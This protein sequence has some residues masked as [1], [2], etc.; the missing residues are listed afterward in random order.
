MPV[1][2]LHRLAVLSLLVLFSTCAPPRAT[3]L[4]V[5]E[6]GHL[7][8]QPERVPVD[9]GRLL[10]AN[11]I[12]G[13]GDARRVYEGTLEADGVIRIAGVPEGPWVLELRTRPGEE[14]PEDPPYV[15][16]H[17]IVGGEG[18][19]TVGSRYWARRPKETFGENSRLT[20]NLGVPEG[21]WDG[22][23]LTFVSVSSLFQREL[24]FDSSATNQ[25][26]LPESGATTTSGWEVPGSDLLATWGAEASGLPAAARQD[27]LL[28]YRETTTRYQAPGRQPWEPWGSALL[29]RADAVADLGGQTLTA[30]DANV[31]TGT[32]TAPAMRRVA[33]DV[34]GASFLGALRS[35]GQYPETAR[36]RLTLSF[37]QE[38]GAGPGYFASLAPRSWQLSASSQ[39]PAANPACF[40]VDGTCDPA[41]DA[42]DP[43]RLGAVEHP[44]DQALAF[45]APVL[46]GSGLRD[47]LTTTYRFSARWVHPST[48]RPHDLTATA[49]VSAPLAATPI[50]LTLGPVQALTVNGAR[51][52][53]NEFAP[54]QVGLTP[55]IAFEAPALGTAEYYT[56]DFVE[57]DPDQATFGR[58]SRVVATVNTTATTVTAPE[59]VLQAGR[60]YYL[61][62]AARRDGRKW[63][64]PGDYPADT[65]LS[66]AVFTPPFTP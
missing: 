33:L 26:N 60:Y 27:D 44:G 3:V 48:E 18:S 10:A 15:V 40:P 7:T 62:V 29:T 9:T 11:A 41:C 46:Y 37:T 52:A 5:D 17:P 2:S 53:F 28:V 14:H 23:S 30:T 63:T 47:V 56:V 54:A 51:L 20:L 43:S 8:G 31:L 64:T 22:D 16:Q 19:V 35:A 4:L 1:S 32:F 36:S 50:E 34:K 57:L 42:C 45:E 13:S 49:T 65:L 66:T 58:D 6:W 55:T 61:R 38:A 21:L 39:T 24:Q 25:R 12:V 59:A